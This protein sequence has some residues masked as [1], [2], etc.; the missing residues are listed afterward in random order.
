MQNLLGEN[1]A[2]SLIKNALKLNPGNGAE[3]LAIKRALSRVLSNV[4]AGLVRAQA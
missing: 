3:V 2:E 4:R 1:L